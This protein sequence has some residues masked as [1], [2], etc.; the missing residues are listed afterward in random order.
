MKNLKRTL[1]F[2]D[3]YNLEIRREKRDVP[4][5]RK[6]IFAQVLRNVMELFQQYFFRGILFFGVARTEPKKTH[7]L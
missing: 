2:I 6:K 7:S 4:Q 3:V 5:N 1:F